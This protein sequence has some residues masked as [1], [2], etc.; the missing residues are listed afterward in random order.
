M[1][2]WTVRWSLQSDC[3]E[4]T[5]VWKSFWTYLDFCE[6]SVDFRYSLTY[7]ANKNIPLVIIHIIKKERKLLTYTVSSFSLDYQI[8]CIIFTIVLIHVHVASLLRRYS[9]GSSRNLPPHK[10]KR[11]R[12]KPR[13]RVYRGGFH[14]TNQTPLSFVTWM[15]TPRPV[16]ITGWIG[17]SVKSAYKLS[18]SSGCRT[19]WFR[20]H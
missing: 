4:Q 1:H 19:S 2:N 3:N 16:L 7:S 15:T 10:G 14:E 11:L 12:D 6:P 5:M 13:E 20:W 8:L 18:G 9:V 17:K